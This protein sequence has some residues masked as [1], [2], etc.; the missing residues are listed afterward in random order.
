MEDTEQIDMQYLKLYFIGLPG[1]GK[2]TFRKRLTRSLVNISSLPLKDRQHYSTHLA[3]CIQTLCILQDEEKF[4]LEISENLDD[5]LKAFF[6]YLL[7][8]TER[9][10][11]APTD[12]DST[13]AVHSE[14]PL[15]S[16][17]SQKLA[18]TKGSSTQLDSSPVGES[19][20]TTEPTE[21]DETKS[22]LSR[23]LAEIRGVVTSG[24]YAEFISMHK[25]LLNI[26]DIGGQ[27][28]FLE[29][30]P[31]I[32]GGPG[33]F[34]V[35]FPLDKEFDKRYEIR[36]QRDE[37]RITPYEANY[38]IRE[39]IAQILSGISYHTSEILP[40]NDK[41]KQ[42]TSV[43]PTITL[44]GTFKDELER[45][46]E[47]EVRDT[48][49]Q[50]V[51]GSE[52]VQQQ[53]TVSEQVA[54]KTRQRLEELHKSVKETT[55]KSY[56]SDFVVPA[57]ARENKIFFEVD[58]YEG[59]DKDLEPIRA[60]IRSCLRDNKG[61][62]KVP[63]RPVQLL[64]SIILRKEYQIVKLE[65]CMKIGNELNMDED[66][67]DFTLW[68]FNQLGTIIY[69]PEIG[70][71]FK[72]NVICSP[73]VIFNSISTLITKPL[74]KLHRYEECCA[75]KHY[76]NWIEK[77][78]F[79]LETIQQ[80]LPSSG[81]DQKVIPLEN[82]VIFLEH[83]HL[84]SPIKA[85]EVSIHGETS[86]VRYFMP[87]ILDCATQEELLTAPVPNNDTPV[88]L[89]LFF[90][91]GTSESFADSVPIGLFCAMIAKLVSD[92]DDGIFGAKWKLAD[93][94]VKR[95]IVSFYVD[96]YDHVVTLVSHAGCY[97]IRV[98]RSVNSS[99]D[100]YDL[101]TYV[102]TTIMAGLKDLNH[103]VCPT[104]GFICPCG[105]HQDTRLRVLDNSCVIVVPIRR[106][107]AFFKCL[108]TNKKVSLVDKQYYHPWITKVFVNCSEFGK[109]C[110]FLFL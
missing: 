52:V 83:V 105:Q 75:G 50:Q 53:N 8:M 68:Y 22:K 69:R 7:G 14:S 55:S 4:D 59:D 78:Q 109:Y 81:D 74:L 89:L 84:I 2:T 18:S 95:N 25:I 12:S 42:F 63:I 32:C 48:I 20:E 100:L 108:K 45:Q 98:T 16:N 10:E 67:V 24:N 35:F 36:Y 29:M 19:N 27:P 23:V 79:S 34:F 62:M 76:D 73:Q 54:T 47:K 46:M 94:R 107:S 85:K 64:F 56:F 37:D 110:L 6:K 104:I 17:T 88:S 92:G 91:Y 97:E 3:E 13:Q 90:K 9:K 41:Y 65:D 40:V 82:L 71:W 39:T 38:S 61:S 26:I 80:S 15:D 66:T 30:L 86:V 70:G 57:N 31:F 106:E 11:P 101:C 5:E 51:S 103:F 93:A 28:G 77:G 58:N 102:Y 33:I 49:Q 99:I 87:A 44:I 60:H 21:T 1:V 72:K 96:V 43:K